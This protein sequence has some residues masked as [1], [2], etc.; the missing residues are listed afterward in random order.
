MEH[1]EMAIDSIRVALMN[2][3]RALILKDKAGKR[4]LPMWV[5]E[6]EADAIATGLIN[7]RPGDSG[8]LVYDFICLM[9]N[10]LGAVLKY[11][12]IDKYVRETFSAKVFLEKEGEFLE[13]D[14]RPSD[15]LATAIRACAPIY[16]T[17]KIGLR[18]A[19]ALRDWA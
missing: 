3:K 15:A 10:K 2:N 6:Y 7:A 5:G 13:I 11:V 9:I 19:P 8:P 17:E 18:I 12:V 4:Y 14:C 1:V 16:V